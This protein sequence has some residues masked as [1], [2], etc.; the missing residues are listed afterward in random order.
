MSYVTQ[1]SKVGDSTLYDARV[2]VKDKCE[3]V[4]DQYKFVNESPKEQ[5]FPF[6]S[7]S[8]N[9]VF[10]VGRRVMQDKNAIN[11]YIIKYAK[12]QSCFDIDPCDVYAAPYCCKK[13]TKAKTV[14]HE[15][16]INSKPSETTEVNTISG[17]WFFLFFLVIGLFSIV[18]IALLAYFMLLDQ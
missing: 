15:E 3:I 17:I 7:T 12:K 5:Q 14:I 6:P 10:M 1:Y 16:G 2:C 18:L 13:N 4:Q 8:D 11:E 9:T